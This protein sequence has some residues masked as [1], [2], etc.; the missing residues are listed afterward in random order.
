VGAIVTANQLTEEDYDKL[1]MAIRMAERADT[2]AEFIDRKVVG[3]FV[4]WMNGTN[5]RWGKYNQRLEKSNAHL[6]EAEGYLKEANEC[7]KKGD[8]GAS[9]KLLAKAMTR[10]NSSKRKRYFV[11]TYLWLHHKTGKITELKL[12]KDI[13][14]R[15]ISKAL[16]GHFAKR[17]RLVALLSGGASIGVHATSFAEH[18]TNG[19]EAAALL[20]YAGILAGL[21]ARRLGIMHGVAKDLTDKD[22]LVYYRGVD[23]RKRHS[24]FDKRMAWS[25]LDLRQAENDKRTK[26]LMGCLKSVHDK[27]NH[28]EKLL[29]QIRPKSIKERGHEPPARLWPEPKA[30]P[31]GR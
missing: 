1:G 8:Y 14:P 17:A 4:G 7:I 15:E 19:L 13:T 23:L 16:T 22:Q 27:W 29:S 30:K 5:K 26:E 18:S 10:F 2:A 6:L 3:K 11:E 31:L 25:L 20:A 24:D 21:T 12:A 9:K 28:S